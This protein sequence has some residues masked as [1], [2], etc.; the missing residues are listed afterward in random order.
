[1]R[2]ENNKKGKKISK[3]IYDLKISDIKPE[4]EQDSTQDIT[5]SVEKN[6]QSNIKDNANSNSN[7]NKI[8]KFRPVFYI[9]INALRNERDNTSNGKVSQDNTIT[10]DEEQNNNS[11]SPLN[12]E[13][14]N[15]IN[16][17]MKDSYLKKDKNYN[18]NDYTSNNYYSNEN[19]N[20]LLYEPDNE[21]YTNEETYIKKTKQFNYN[22]P[23]NKI[24]QLDNNNNIPIKNKKQFN[25]NI[26]IDKI[27]QLN[28]NIFN[29]NI[30]VLDNNNNPTENIKQFNNIIPIDKIKQNTN[31]NKESASTTS[32]EKIYKN[33]YI[34]NN[35]NKKTFKLP[36]DAIIKENNEVYIEIY[37][38]VKPKKKPAEKKKNIYKEKPI[39]TIPITEIKKEKEKEKEKNIKQNNKKNENIKLNKINEINE[40]E[41]LKRELNP[42]LYI[43][44]GLLKN[45]NNFP[46][47][48]I[49]KPFGFNNNINNNIYNMYN[50]YYNNNIYSQNLNYIIDQKMKFQKLKQLGLLAIT[51]PKNINHYL[52]NKYIN[53]NVGNVNQFIPFNNNINY[54]NYN[55]FNNFGNQN[56]L[57]R[58]YLANKNIMNINPVNNINN[59]N[60][61][62]NLTNLNNPEKYTITLKSKTNDP[63]IEK[64]SKIQVTTSYI[65]D[66]SKVK[67]ESTESAKK[68]KNMKNIINLE[69]IISG[70]ETRT[71]VRLNPIPP[72]YSSFDISKLLDKYLKIESGKK[73]RIYKALYTPLCKIIGKN[74]GY[75]FIMMAKPKYVIEFYNT[76]MGRSLGKKKC[77]KPCNVI[78]ADIQ[79]NDFLK[80]NE[81]DPIR[82]PITFR[83]IRDD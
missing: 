39:Y 32:S 29:E 26:P 73:Q 23:I 47:Q 64:I 67:Q 40:L 20:I 17:E 55:N 51:N 82:K 30:E 18:S 71:V 81:D 5:E 58:N 6:Q 27:K 34:A 28:Y 72:N 45:Q 70:K 7:E 63:T 31:D 37:I 65:K 42:N 38:R 16:R 69:D 53:N 9:D 48:N 14:A 49:N 56:P 66:N 79:G 10:T 50:N 41:K 78:W 33:K 25:Y 57:L 74:L 80:T 4:N 36:I 52:I 11:E 21:K 8:K 15:N 2:N 19:P 24:K 22:I 83:D 76:F 68:E 1:M 60:N 61:L 3:P 46:I 44:N 13:I 35:N 54:N 62:N 43:N 12:E 59:I 77:K 75:C